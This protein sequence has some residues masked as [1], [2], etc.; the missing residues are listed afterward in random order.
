MY[1]THFLFVNIWNNI[2]I[3]SK[4]GRFKNMEDKPS[5]EEKHE[6]ITA[7]NKNLRKC[8]DIE[9]LD[10]ILKLLQKTNAYNT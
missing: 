6:Y 10:F 8:D 4:K 5:K 1:D 3:H 7:I 2:F 9:I